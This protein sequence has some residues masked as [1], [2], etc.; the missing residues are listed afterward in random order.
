MR[1]LFLILTAVLLLLNVA[2]AEP[3]GED[4]LK[5]LISGMSLRDKAAQMMIPAFRIWR[6]NSGS[7]GENITKINDEI[8]E[9]VSRD[10][11]GGILLFGQNF[12]GVEQTLRL[13]SDLQT[14][15]QTGGGLPLIIFADQEGGSVNRI[16]FGTQGVGNMALGATG[17][18]EKARIMASIIGEEMGLLGIHA[19]FAPVVD[20]NNN[21]SNPVIG[22][23]S[24]SDDPEIV[25]EFGCAYLSG[26]HDSGT[27]AALKHFPGHG[28]TDVNS[29]TGLPLINSTYEELKETELVPF[30]AAIDAG[31]DMVMTAHIQYPQIE[32]R[33][34]LSVSTGEQIYLPATMSPT[35]LTDILRGDMGF[36]GVIVADSLDMKAI[37][38]NFSVEDT[39]K[40][41]IEAGL[42]LL[43]LPGV[44]DMETFHLTDRYV[45]IAV[46]LVENGEIDE[47]RLEESVYRILKLKQKYGVLDLNDFTVTEEKIAAARNGIGSK[48]HRDTE[49][50]IA[51]QALTLLK[52]KDGAFPLQVSEGEKTL[53][54]F[55]DS[56]ASRLGTGDLAVRMLKNRG[57]LPENGEVLVMKNT[58]DNAEECIQTA[59][60]ADHVILIHRM[61]NAACLDPATDDGFSSETFD[62]IIEAVHAQ[63]K[64][65]ILS[66]WGSSM[67]T[68]PEEVTAAET[69]SELTSFWCPN[70]PT[71][72]LSCFGLCEPEG[73]LPVNIPSLDETYKPVGDILWSRGQCAALT[74]QTPDYSEEKNWVSVPE[75]IAYEADTF[76]ILPTV[77][78]KETEAGNE[79]ITNTR[80]ASRFI[81]T[82]GMEKG[83]VSEQ[84]NVYAPYYRQVT[85]AAYLN[86]DG[87][88]DR[89][90]EGEVTQ[91]REIAYGDIRNA[92]LYYLEHLNDGRPV[93][94]FGYSQGAEMVKMLLAEFG[95]EGALRDRLVAAY[96]IGEPV[97]KEY[98]AKYP[99]LQ[100]AQGETDTGVIISY[101]A[102]DARMNPTGPWEL[103]INPLNWKTDRTP[104]LKESNLGFVVANTYGE[105]TQEVPAYCG[106]YLDP[107]SGRLVVTDADNQDELY[108]GSGGVFE[109][110]DYHMYD[111]NLFYRNLEKNVGDR[112]KAFG[113]T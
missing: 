14:G 42:D 10:H 51:T 47:A 58:R 88:F 59:T 27:M 109:T 104:A 87:K 71:A 98:I 18:P 111:L 96:V 113:K 39:L 48:E 105:I 112:I 108:A 36:D 74:A 43:I 38:D 32:T 83:I 106:A 69:A 103:S 81:K 44:T 107:E 13:V 45:D 66:Y 56:C 84:T 55:A 23:R 37:T 15:N 50:Q 70:L 100:M 61:Y 52:N 101:N 20:V 63:G 99:Y 46:E 80:K 85:L 2:F 53:M 102:I 26:L 86:E 31:A 68:I 54:L 60:E 9:M 4:E 64:K 6:R 93:V 21:A 29:H 1:K 3:G 90:M 79:D 82:F 91:Y 11:F 62:R 34:Y 49:E 5:A 110:G 16:R 77:N 92:W 7:N 33:T 25:A 94:L 12:T 41:C 76:F 28:N 65:V 19:N 97:T 72:L 67:P 35:I 40:L 30:Q 22:I 17:D 78:M 73:I 8:L 89:N 95:G 75:S 57:A 24:F